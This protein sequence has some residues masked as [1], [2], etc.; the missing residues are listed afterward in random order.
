MKKQNTLLSLFFCLIVSLQF[1]RAQ[2]I[3]LL[4][5]AMIAKNDSLELVLNQQQIE[6]DSMISLLKEEKFNHLKISDNTIKK[7]TQIKI[8]KDDIDRQSQ[9]SNWIIVLLVL[10][11]I[12]AISFLVI[13]NKR[14]NTSN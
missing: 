6:I 10:V 5:H 13:K 3:T 1:L 9:K 4:D 2:D 11:T 14:G 12:G 7:D 8:L